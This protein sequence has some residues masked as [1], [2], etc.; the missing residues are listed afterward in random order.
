M[1]LVVTLRTLSNKINHM[2]NLNPPHNPVQSEFLKSLIAPMSFERH[3]AQPFK[4]AFAY[5]SSG[6]SFD[7]NGPGKNP[8]DEHL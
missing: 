1:I 5:M 8:K 3:G 7:P 6:C 2:S 4:V